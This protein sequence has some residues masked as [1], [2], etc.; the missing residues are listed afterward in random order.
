MCALQLFRR[1][2]GGVHRAS[3]GEEACFRPSAHGQLEKS[4]PVFFEIAIVRMALLFA[5]DLPVAIQKMGDFPWPLPET[6]TFRAG[7]RLGIL[8]KQATVWL[9]SDDWWLIVD[10]WYLEISRVMRLPAVL[11]HFERWGFSLTKTNQPTSYWDTSHLWKNPNR[12]KR[13][14]EPF[15][16][17]DRCAKLLHVKTKITIITIITW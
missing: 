1:S 14:N 13:W 8:L 7:P 5:L 3:P 4:P 15:D 11:I 17:C 9:I 16:W 6:A 2:F 10:K 12:Y